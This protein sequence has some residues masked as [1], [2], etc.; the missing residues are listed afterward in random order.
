MFVYHAILSKFAFDT[1]EI[2]LYQVNQLALLDEYGNQKQMSITHDTMVTQLLRQGDEKAFSL[3][4]DTLWESL[5]SYVMRILHDREDTMD[6]V[7][8]TFIDL[9]QQRNTLA[10]VNSIRSYIFSIARYKA[11]RYIRLNIEKRDYLASLIE[12]FDEYE[13]SVESQLFTQ[14][15]QR[16]IDAE[17]AN[18]PQKMREVF[19]L[20]REKNLSYKE[21]AEQLNISDKTVKKQ[22]S[23][24]LKIL[25]LKLNDRNYPTLLVALILP[26]YPIFFLW[27]TRPY[28]S[29]E[30]ITTTK[31]KK[32]TLPYKTIIDH[33]L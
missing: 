13:K 33:W 19:V 5:F 12:F 20:S 3:L 27:K 8:E 29:P 2:K 14:E 25:R 9:W 4:Y 7:Q 15:L 11:L 32:T 31:A 28:I 24:S 30:I 26:Y 22:I 17:V 10:N 16:I 1:G 23:N 21:I 6:I 18:L